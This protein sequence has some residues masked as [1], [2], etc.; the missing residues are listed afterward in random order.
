[1]VGLWACELCGLDDI[2]ACL[3]YAYAL[4][5]GIGPWFHNH[6]QKA[7]VVEKFLWFVKLRGTNGGSDERLL[8][9]DFVSKSYDVGE[10]GARDVESVTELGG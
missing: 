2:F 3:E 5:S 6:G 7:R 4:T 1:M 10:S 8:H 9:G